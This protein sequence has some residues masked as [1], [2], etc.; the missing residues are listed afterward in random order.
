MQC[1]IDVATGEAE[2]SI[3]GLDSFGPAAKTGVRGP[4]SY[5]I[6]FAN[7]DDQLILWVDGSVVEFNAPTTYGR[8]DNTR[9]R[10]ADLSPVGVASLGAALRIGHLKLF[11]DVYYIADRHGGPGGL[12]TDF[13]ALALPFFPTP[14][15]VARFLSDPT[16]WDAFAAMRWEDFS[17]GADQFLE[18]YVSRELLLG[19]ALWVFWPH[20]PA[21]IP[22]TDIPCFPNVPRMRPVR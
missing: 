8:L 5:E 7:V 10:P 6:R 4:G 14:E 13:D 11:R 15:G 16:R 19:K 22:G 20:S 18:H 21:A 12:L 2:L 3:E 9:P 1:R 17:L